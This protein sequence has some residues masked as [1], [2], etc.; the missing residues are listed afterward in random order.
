MVKNFYHAS[1]SRAFSISLH[2]YL[3]VKRGNTIVAAHVIMLYLF[4][5]EDVERVKL[6]TDARA[7]KKTSLNITVTLLFICDLMKLQVKYMCI[8]HG[9]VVIHY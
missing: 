6:F 7:Y 9:M 8:V 3:S 4:F 2:R 5:T 1:L